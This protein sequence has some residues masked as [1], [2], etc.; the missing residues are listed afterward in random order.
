MWTFNEYVPARIE[1][2]PSYTDRSPK[3]LFYSLHNVDVMERVECVVYIYIY[4]VKKC[5]T[6]FSLEY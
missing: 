3:V 5:S 1:L 6:I 4:I 2:Y